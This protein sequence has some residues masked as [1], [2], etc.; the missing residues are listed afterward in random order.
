MSLAA[1]GGVLVGGV[2]MG[3]TGSLWGMLA[4]VKFIGVRKHQTKQNRELHH[5][6]IGTQGDAVSFSLLLLKS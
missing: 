3:V 5:R 1:V 4:E 6:S 2:G